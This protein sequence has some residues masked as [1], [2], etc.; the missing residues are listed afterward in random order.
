MTKTYVCENCD[1]DIREELVW[2][3]MASTFCGELC[4]SEGTL[5]LAVTDDE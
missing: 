2:W 3:C 5:E 4:A 1:K